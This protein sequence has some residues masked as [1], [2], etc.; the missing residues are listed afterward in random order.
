MPTS[1]LVLS[2]DERLDAV[3]EN[4]RL[5]QRK[6]GLTF[7]TDAYLLAAFVKSGKNGRGADFG[8]GSGIISLL[9][10]ARRNYSKIHAFEIQPVYADLV[11]RNTV[12][13]GFGDII[14][15][16]CMDVREVTQTVTGGSLTSIWSN[17]PYLPQEGGFSNANE[18]MRI[19]RRE[20]NGTIDDFCAAASR[21]LESGGSFYTVYRP[22]RLAELFFALQKNR[23]Q[24]KRM[25]TVYP[26]MDSKPCLVLTEAQKDAAPSLKQSRPLLIYQSN[27]SEKTYTP[28]MQ[29]VYDSFSLDFLF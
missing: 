25:I 29:Q 19:A 15:A 23:L 21:L 3:Y 22:D 10:A 27:G 4:I 24:P 6:K 18:E 16:H 28:A 2:P 11:Q 7:G 12:L 14:S 26:D 5:I 20:L 1:S 13:N 17:P 8:A 9:C